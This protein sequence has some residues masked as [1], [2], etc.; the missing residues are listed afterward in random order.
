MSIN[1]INK[2]SLN[3][4]MYLCKNA[5]TLKVEMKFLTKTLKTKLGK[6]KGV[7]SFFVQLYFINLSLISSTFIT[8]NIILVIIDYSFYVLLSHCP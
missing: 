6:D 2:A 1:L 8:N 7:L 4:E 3:I 5:D